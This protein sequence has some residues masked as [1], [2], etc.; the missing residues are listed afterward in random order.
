[1]TPRDHPPGGEMAPATAADDRHAGDPFVAIG[2]HDELG[3]AVQVAGGEGG[4]L[5]LEERVGLS[6]PAGERPPAVELGCAEGV[7]LQAEVL[8]GLDIVRVWRKVNL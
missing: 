1:M 7:D 5:R 3:V 4:E 2:N 6:R 8:H